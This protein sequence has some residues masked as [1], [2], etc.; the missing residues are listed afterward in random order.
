MRKKIPPAG[1]PFAVRERV[2]N[3]LRE[4]VR[5]SAYGFLSSSS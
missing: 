1:S 2:A 3:R 4:G 5:D